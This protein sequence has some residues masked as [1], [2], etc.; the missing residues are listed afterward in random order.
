MAIIQVGYSNCLESAD[1]IT[2]TSSATNYST[3]RLKDRDFGKLWLCGSTTT[4][5][6]IVINQST[7]PIASNCLIA[8]KHTLDTLG[9]IL[10]YGSDGVSYS[11]RTSWTQSGTGLIKIPYTATTPNFW[12]LS[13][14]SG[15]GTMRIAELMLTNLVS[16]TAQPQQGLKESK[17][18]CVKSLESKTGISTFLSFTTSKKNLEYSLIVGSTDKTYWQNVQTYFDTYG[19]FFFIDHQ[20]NEFIAE[21]V[22]DLVFTPVSAT[23][24]ELNVKLQEVI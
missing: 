17:Y 24:Y 18:F 9:L 13:H 4:P 7:T 21:L 8:Y 22:D 14:T 3:N 16:F 2:A 15:T 20:G 19:P 5:Q 6:R 12:R 11:T 1:S 23:S 10:E